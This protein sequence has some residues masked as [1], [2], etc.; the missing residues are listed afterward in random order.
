MKHTYCCCF[1]H[2]ALGSGQQQQ[3][4]DFVVWQNWIYIHI[5]DNQVS[6]AWRCTFG[7]AP[8]AREKFNVWDMFTWPPI[9]NRQWPKKKKGLFEVISGGRPLTGQY[10]N[11]QAV[12][13]NTM[14]DTKREGTTLSWYQ[15]AS[16]EALGG[17]P[18]STDYTCGKVEAVR[19]NYHAA[20]GGLVL[21]KC[22]WTWPLSPGGAS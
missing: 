11:H 6:C 4:K 20:R 13:P 5:D 19:R 12:R 1:L 2:V 16:L 10:K 15:P 22:L 3:K 9:S 8:P 14:S 7:I 18:Q 17:G 21:D